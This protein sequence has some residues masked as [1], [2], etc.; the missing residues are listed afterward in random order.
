[1]T[2]LWL[3]LAALSGGVLYHT[4][5]QVTDGR[6]KLATINDDL[7]KE[8]ETI[9]VLQAEWG[10]LNQPDRLEKLSKQYLDLAPLKGKQFAKLGDIP[11]QPDAPAVAAAAAAIATTATT[12]ATPPSTPAASADKAQT[13][14]SGTPPAKAETRPARVA[15]APVV[16]IRKPAAP[17]KRPAPVATAQSADRSFADVVK[18]LG[19]R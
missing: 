3:F 1:M 16:K 5:Q 10:Y 14:A 6:Q 19:V 18:S 11:E 17:P 12:A 9:R 2:L 15:K 13:L 4:S 8:D 7:R